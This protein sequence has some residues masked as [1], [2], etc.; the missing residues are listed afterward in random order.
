MGKPSHKRRPVPSTA[1]PGK[2]SSTRDSQNIENAA[3]GMASDEGSWESGHLIPVD[4]ELSVHIER[5]PDKCQLAPGEDQE[6][7]DLSNFIEPLDLS[8]SFS[9][10]LE[11]EPSVRT[12]PVNGGL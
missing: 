6:V 7:N 3:P 4:V 12:S 1:V 10:P 2:L 11:V 9:V 8:N 5:T